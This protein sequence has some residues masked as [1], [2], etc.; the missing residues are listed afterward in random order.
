MVENNASS[1]TTSTSPIGRQAAAGPSAS[2]SLASLLGEAALK[3][4]RID[5]PLVASVKVLSDAVV[6]AVGGADNRVGSAQL[7]GAMV[8]FAREARALM[9]G[10]PDLSA[11]SRNA[12]VTNAIEAGARRS[13]SLPSVGLSALDH[14]IT[15]FEEASRSLSSSPP[16][17]LFDPAPR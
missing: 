14:A 8:D 9:I 6:S 4:A 1:F 10:N 12:A 3:T 16:V 15:L 13:D 2:S 17:P 5:G 7:E 11:A